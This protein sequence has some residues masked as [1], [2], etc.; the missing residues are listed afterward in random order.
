MGQ[1]SEVGQNKSLALTLL[2]SGDSFFHSDEQPELNLENDYYP[3]KTGCNL[4]TNS[5][6]SVL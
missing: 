2:R 5:S 4:K 1:R 6:I 3:N